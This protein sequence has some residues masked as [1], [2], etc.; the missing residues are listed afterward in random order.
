MALDPEAYELLKRQKRTDESFS[1]AV[2]RLAR[3]RVPLPP[4]QASG[5]ICPLGER[6]EIDRV[7]ADLHAAD[8]RHADRIR[9]QW[10][11]K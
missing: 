6:R 7:Y 9:R 1:N 8:R 2:K 11:A 5:R 10:K 3:P 4:S